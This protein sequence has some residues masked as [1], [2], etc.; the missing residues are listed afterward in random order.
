MTGND[1]ISLNRTATFKAGAKVVMHTCFE[2]RIPKYKDKIW[3]C[4]T[5]S[6]LSRSKEEVV[7]LEDF[8]GYFSVEFLKS[9]D[10]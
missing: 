9:S 7:F 3:T 1:Y 10:N 5:D 6:F 2:A 8:S 4:K